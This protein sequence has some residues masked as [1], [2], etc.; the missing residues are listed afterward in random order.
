[1]E[2][3][4]IIK[5]VYRG[6]N[7]LTPKVMRYGW[8]GEKAVFELSRGTGIE[9]QDKLFGVTVALL[10]PP[11]RSEKSK[12]LFS[13]LKAEQYIIQLREEFTKKED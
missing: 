11:R 13:R 6:Y 12:V 5:Q 8:L 4:Q 3:E 7:I 10:N 1:M 9:D 2:P